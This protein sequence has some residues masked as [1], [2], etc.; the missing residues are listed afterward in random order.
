VTFQFNIV[1]PSSSAISI[2]GTDYQY[3]SEQLRRLQ[4]R[5][6]LFY[7]IDAARW[8]GEGVF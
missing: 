2:N 5:H 1:R 4:I 3:P 7:D 6:N 8:N